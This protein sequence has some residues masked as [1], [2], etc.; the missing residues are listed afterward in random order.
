MAH[1]HIH[2]D[3]GGWF[4]ANMMAFFIGLIVLAALVIGLVAWQPWDGSGSSDG[5]GS[6]SGIDINIGG[7]G[8]GEGS[9]DSGSGGGGD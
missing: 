3:G 9:G 6:G 1:D 2:S 4:A 5:S 8:G 7:G